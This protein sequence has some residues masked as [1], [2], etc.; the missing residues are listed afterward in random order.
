MVSGSVVA[1]Q[2]AAVKGKGHRKFLEAYIV[3]YLV[4]LL[5]I[6]PGN[7]NIKFDPNSAVDVELF[8]GNDIARLN[9]TP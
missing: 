1:N 4:E 7:I 6:A 8:L 5:R 2:P 9:L 3:K